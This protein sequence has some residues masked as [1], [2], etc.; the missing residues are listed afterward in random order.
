M[1]GKRYIG[2]L[3]GMT[4]RQHRFNVWQHQYN[5]FN[6]GK[7]YNTRNYM[8]FCT[9][10]GYGLALFGG[11]CSNGSHGD[12]HVFNF[13]IQ[14]NHQNI[15]ALLDKYLDLLGVDRG[16]QFCVGRSPYSL[17]LPTL[18]KKKP[19]DAF[20]VNVSRLHTNNRWLNEALHAHYKNCWAIFRETI[21]ASHRDYIDS[22]LGDV[23]AIHNY[24]KPNGFVKDQDPSDPF[25]NY[26]RFKI[27]TE[28]FQNDLLDTVD[29]LEAMHNMTGR[30]P[31]DSE[32]WHQV[33]AAEVLRI[34]PIFKHFSQ[35]SDDDIR[36]FS[37]GNY[38]YKLRAAYIA[39]NNNE[40]I[41]LHVHGAQINYMSW[42]EKCD[43][44]ERKIKAVRDKHKSLY[45]RTRR[46]RVSIQDIDS[47]VQNQSEDAPL[48]EQ[49]LERIQKLNAKLVTMR[50]VCQEKEQLLNKLLSERDE[51]DDEAHSEN[52][53]RW[54][55]FVLKVQ[56]INGRHTRSNKPKT[57][58]S[59]YWAFDSAAYLRESSNLRT[60]LER[61]QADE[62]DEKAPVLEDE[63]RF[64]TPGQQDGNLNLDMDIAE[65]DDEMQPQPQQPLSVPEVSQANTVAPVVNANRALIEKQWEELPVSEKL[66]FE[67]KYAALQLAD[68]DGFM[69]YKG[70][71]REMA[72]QRKKYIA[73]NKKRRN[74]LTKFI[75]IMK[76][77]ED[78]EKRVKMKEEAQATFRKGRAM[79]L[80]IR[81]LGFELIVLRNR[82]RACRNA[83][84]HG[85]PRLILPDVPPVPDEGELKERDHE[86]LVEIQQKEMRSLF[87]PARI[88]RL[89]YDA[90]VIP[91]RIKH[92]KSY[93][94]P[95]AHGA[96]TIGCC[97]HRTMSLEML[98]GA[99]GGPEFWKPH[100]VSQ[101][102]GDVLIN[103]EDE[104]TFK[105]T[106][107]GHWW[108][109]LSD[110]QQ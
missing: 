108:D 73:S 21:W 59:N 5:T 15:N 20:D 103:V 67:V 76:V 56:G 90:D 43:I 35:L 17:L 65:T 26:F 41:T 23:C 18:S 37:G 83:R 54:K 28:F 49:M 40:N 8:S 100:E 25:M 45:E 42:V 72:A 92:L 46:L 61:K 13:L 93:C 81:K 110:S 38:G 85:P 78:T 16:W 58:Y 60:Q 22:W 106:R 50:A 84:N 97:A 71:L 82:I 74:E 11:F 63:V 2:F 4:M 68:Q 44:I 24:M 62:T 31:S 51:I 39:H 70:T 9:T 14:N 96:R 109:D 102:Q 69:R 33:D 66:P 107:P 91:S 88:Q 34:L 10:S 94:W 86:T 99:F 1:T 79:K 89:Q 57:V 87:T 19:V 7:G 48:A 6:P 77:E 98:R 105:E 12:S 29:K 52:L 27:K 104:H 55:Y 32:T 101:R 64:R 75:R 53:W 3:D 95:C 80:E 36:L 47:R 30:E